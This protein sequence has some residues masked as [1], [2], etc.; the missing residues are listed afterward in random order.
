[1]IGTTLS[2]PVTDSSTTFWVRFSAAAGGQ[3]VAE[4]RDGSSSQ[5]MWAL[6]YDGTQGGFWFYPRTAS[7][8]AAIFTGPGTAQVN[9]WIKVEVQYTAT[10][11]GGAQLYL[12]GQTQVAWGVSGDYRRSADLQKLLLWNDVTNTVDF[13]D[14]V[15]A[16][17]TAPPTTVPG[18]PTG[19]SGVP[20][21]QATHLTWTAPTTGGGAIT[22]Y[23]ITPFIGGTAQTP[24]DTASPATSYTVSGLTNGTAYTFKV[25]GINSVGTGA[26]SA[27][28][29][30]IIPAPLNAIQIENRQPGD[31]N[32]GDFAGPP[33]PTAIS[34]YGSRISVNHG[35]SI[36][37][38]VT[39]TASTVSINVYRMGWYEGAGARLMRSMG[40]FPGVNQP[41]ALPNATTGMI[42]ENWTRTATLDVPSNWTTG[43]YLA[44][45]SASNGYAALIFFVVRDD[46]GTQ[47]IVF[48][49][50][51]NTYQAY[52]VYGGTSLYN[53]N[54]DHSIYTAAHAMKV[55]YDR[56][57]LNG[58]GAGE[59]LRWEYPFV[60]WAEKQGYNLTYTTNVDVDTNVNPLTAHKAFLSVGHDEY[61]S[62]GIRDNVEAAIAAGVDVGFFAGNEA[63]WQVRYENNA[64][65]VPSRVMVG[66]K[67]YASGL[68]GPPGPDPMY[69][70]N[71]SI[72]TT[73]WRDPIVARPEE[74]IMG[75]MFGGEIVDA[76]YIVQNASSWV[77][78]GTGWANGTH[79][80][81]LVG[82]EYDHYFG[83][84][85]TPPNT[86]VLSNTP[87]VNTENGQQDTA[88]STVYTAPSGATVFAVGTIQWSWGLDSFG[89][90]PTY[91]NA[92]VQR[93]TANILARFLQP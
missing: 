42:S 86:T 53:N 55:S 63:Y 17:V 11:T 7:G 57:F 49:T 1:V 47:P 54:T 12:N 25:A 38:Y 70:V 19:V 68:N 72:V 10:A 3:S 2:A 85:Y 50:S 20:D 21:D 27:A 35:Q 51:T 84:A 90:G 65:G 28:S 64:S 23:R 31:P 82:Y 8:G 52:N 6:S 9:T 40:S 71:N 32:W 87:L 4:T 29:A 58:N 24:I 88:N 73:W 62:K 5:T 92:G 77:F 13:D 26:D 37:F 74:S 34:G 83:D 80:P 41:Q 48:Q 76:D 14:V 78:D 33:G 44:R 79:V 93:T 45:L 91:V 56:P 59:F 18:Q 16:G 22:S 46:G 89:G 39:T 61:W 81:R 69:G 67:D 36:D 43:V 60:R 15:V 30:A 75:V 66:Y